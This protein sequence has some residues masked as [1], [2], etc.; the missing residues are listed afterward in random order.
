MQLETIIMA[1]RP[2]EKLYMAIDRL[3]RQNVAPDR[4]RVVLTAADRS[5]FD[6]VRSR[7]PYD[8]L[9]ETVTP[10]KFSH[11]TTRLE[12]ALS[13][14]ADHVLFMTQ[15][16]VPADKHLTEEMLS[17]FD[18]DDIA[19]VYARQLPYPGASDTEKFAR[20]FNYPPVSHISSADDLSALGIRA[21]FCSDTCAMYN[22]R[23]F[24]QLGGF[25]RDVDFNEDMFYAYRALVAGYRISYRAAARV[26]HSH[27][28]TFRQ[29][30]ERYR[31]NAIAQK[32]HPEIF[33]RYPSERAG[34]RYVCEGCRHFIKK[35]SLKG[36]TRFIAESGIRYIGFFVGKHF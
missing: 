24:R 16:A 9:I 18:S 2:D 22:M 31:S 23:I 21:A 19:V 26:L 7:L 29:Q 30:F 4:I 5:E 25:E 12:A 15:D 17:A 34:I 35:G 32:K 28:L 33:D 36:L 1:Y 27:S 13:S 3:S 8:V 6:S 11:G 20:R 10:D 14:P